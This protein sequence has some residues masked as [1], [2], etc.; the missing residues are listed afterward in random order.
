MFAHDFPATFV[1]LQ[2]CRGHLPWI[3]GGESDGDQNR[4]QQGPNLK[5]EKFVG[6]TIFPFHVFDRYEIRIQDFEE[7]VTGIFIIFRFL[8]S[9]N[10]IISKFQIYLPIFKIGTFQILKIFNFQMVKFSHLQ[11]PRSSKS[12]TSKSLV[13]ILPVQTFSK[14]QVPRFTNKYCFK[15]FHVFLHVVKYLYNK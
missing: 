14:C 5:I 9:H 3:R 10:W 7:M 12:K 4:V 11:I 15:R 1:F 6:F 13:Y 8:S 2:I